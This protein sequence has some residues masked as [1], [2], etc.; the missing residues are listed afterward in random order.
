MGKKSLRNKKNNKSG[1]E[2]YSSSDFPFLWSFKNKLFNSGL[3]LAGITV[4][5]IVAGIF[6]SLIIASLPSIKEF[7]IDFLFSTKWNPVIEKFGALPFL[8][9]T[10]LT[11]FL[12]LAI[13]IPFSLAIS[14]LLG[15]YFTE[16]WFASLVKTLTEL[17]AGI[18]SVIYG[19]WGMFFLVPVVRYLENVIGVQPYGIGIFTSSLI[20]AIMIIPYSASLGR[21]VIEMVPSEYKE[22]AY[23][24]GATRFEVI[25]KIILPYSRSGIF[26]GIILALGRAVGETMAVTM[27][28][29]NS[30][31]MPDSIFSPGNTMASVIA[32][33]FNESTFELY[34]SSLI[35]I[36]AVL[37]IVTIVIN[38][39]G[40]YIIKKF[41]VET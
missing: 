23:S 12:A 30:N 4:I 5:L 24:L 16:G 20:L 27:L 40:K 29:G 18:P 21:D 41:E 2:S 3:F 32:N 36:G 35:E 14:I 26:A 6:V 34:T 39:V 9:G 8:V 15:E 22:A 7:G 10:L 37:F 19:F 28:I 33:E 25:K 1:G 13:C 31:K 38:L 17:L 11:S